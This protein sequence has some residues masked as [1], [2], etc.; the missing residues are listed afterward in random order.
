MLSE[1]GQL[2]LGGDATGLSASTV[3]VSE[4]RPARDRW[5][6]ALG[7]LLGF[8]L[9]GGAIAAVTAVRQP[10]SAAKASVQTQQ[11]APIDINSASRAQ[12]KT[13]PGIGE[14]EADRILSGRP[15]R[16]KADLATRE[17]I[18]TG[19]YLS[20]KNRVIAVQA[21]PPKVAKQ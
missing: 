7:M 17:V 11:S 3:E 4:V 12:L 20:L 9:A 18:A 10:A 19:V 2:G 14:V 21:A 6:S 5:L 1:R 16:S 13:L 15:Y 8:T